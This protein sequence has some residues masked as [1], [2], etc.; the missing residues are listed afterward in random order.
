MGGVLVKTP[1]GVTEWHYDH[2]DIRTWLE[3]GTFR[4]YGDPL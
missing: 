2:I 3:T 4:N 1:G